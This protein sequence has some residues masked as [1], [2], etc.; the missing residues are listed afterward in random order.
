MDTAADIIYSRVRYSIS[1]CSTTGVSKGWLWQKSHD[2]FAKMMTVTKS[3]E[4][5]INNAYS[6][7]HAFYSIVKTLQTVS[8]H[9]VDR[10]GEINHQDL[11]RWPSQIT[12]ATKSRNGGTARHRAAFGSL[13]R[14]ERFQLTAQWSR[15][16]F[17]RTSACRYQNLQDFSP[18]NFQRA[19]ERCENSTLTRVVVLKT[20]VL[21]W[22]TIGSISQPL[23]TTIEVNRAGKDRKLN[24]FWSLMS[25][26]RSIWRW[27]LVNFTQQDL[28]TTKIICWRGFESTFTKK[29]VFANSFINIPIAKHRR[30]TEQCLSTCLYSILE[31]RS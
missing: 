23:R 3:H 14:V 30:A 15:K 25:A 9:R 8:S 16:I 27:N 31:Q 18:R 4:S 11:G 26:R 22:R 24:G 7:L 12:T 10:D 1:H 17:G 6:I 13:L 29:F 21:R 19:F 20:I 28:S 2:W 5:N